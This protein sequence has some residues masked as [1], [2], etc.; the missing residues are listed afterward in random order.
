VGAHIEVAQFEALI[1][2]L[3][4]LFM[5]ESLVPGSVQPRGNRSDRG[6]PWGVYPC[7]GED[8][9]CAISVRSDADWRG[10]ASRGVAGV[11]VCCGVRHRRRTTQ[12]HDA[13]DAALAAWTRAAPFELMQVLRG[14]ARRRRHP[15]HQ[16][17]DPHLKRGRSSGGPGGLGR[18][19]EGTPFRGNRLPARIESA[20]LGQHTR[21]LSRR[22]GMSDAEIDAL[23]ADSVFDL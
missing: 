7:A 3:G 15:P 21:G 9:W 6:A 11:G 20:A 8:E 2:F 12:A 18:S 10:L 17:G 16:I 1:Q 5:Q 23:F 14:R 22:L 19:V 4:D 13:I